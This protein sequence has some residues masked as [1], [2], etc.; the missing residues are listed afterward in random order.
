[1]KPMQPMQSYATGRPGDAGGIDLFGGRKCTPK[2]LIGLILSRGPARGAA[3]H[4]IATR[5]ALR[6]RMR[7]QPYM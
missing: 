7:M 3:S 4:L 6:P 5:L 1:M 2:V